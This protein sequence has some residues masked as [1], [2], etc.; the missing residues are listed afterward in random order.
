MPVHDLGYRD[1]C[2]D[3][4]RQWSRPYFIAIGGIALIWRRKWLR[5]MLMLAW[6]PIFVPA[7]GIFTFE[8]SASDPEIGFFAADFIAGP[9][10]RP[11]LAMN[12]VDDPNAARHDVWA[13]LIMSFFRYPQ[14]S[15]MVLLVGLIAPMLIS[16]DLRSRAYLLYFS[17]PLN[18]YEYMI[19]KA[20][21]M[22]FFLGMI[23]TVP[24]L[25]L[26]AIGVMLS[27]DL[28]VVTQTWDIPVRIIGAS[29]VLLVPT[30]ALAMCYSACTS[31]SRYAAFSWFSTWILGFVAYQILTFMGTSGRGRRGR[32]GPPSDLLEAGIDFDR[33]R[34]LSPYH[35]LGKVQSW[36]FGLDT[37]PGSVLPAI[38][39]LVLVTVVGAWVIRRR[40]HATLSR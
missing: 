5:L 13:L 33:W 38:G 34:L 21:V 24:A 27:P 32:R 6:L 31:E 37:T 30:T 26:Y 2:G 16:Y 22:W 20:A 15:A 12:L 35:T 1:W 14:L 36:V 23:V 18:A 7:A 11:D 8:Y 29:F 25:A 3:R 19:G 17:R 39:L 9:M 10:G 40:I 28:S 4:T